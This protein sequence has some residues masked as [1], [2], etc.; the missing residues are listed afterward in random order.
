[1]IQVEDCRSGGGWQIHSPSHCLRAGTAEVAAGCD[2]RHLVYRPIRTC[3]LSA[4]YQQVEQ[5]FVLNE[6]RSGNVLLSFG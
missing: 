1:M 2:I 4:M 6:K 5:A 3:S